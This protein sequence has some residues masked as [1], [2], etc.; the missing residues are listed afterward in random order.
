MSAEHTEDYTKQQIIMATKQYYY[1]LLKQLALRKVAG[2]TVRSNEEQYNR[3]KSMYEIGS[4]ALAD[5]YKTRVSFGQAK[6]EYIAQKNRVIVS[7]YNL[8]FIM[9]RDPRTPISIAET[10]ADSLPR[11]FTNTEIEQSLEKSPELLALKKQVQST[12][13]SYKIAKGQFWPKVRVGGSYSRF[14]PEF[15]RLYDN[16]DKNYNYKRNR[17]W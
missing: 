5:V 17:G 15:E 13:L 9:G 7:K 16:F 14:S 8:N 12:E 2:E 3:T 11:I 4:V 10:E 1:N 6:S